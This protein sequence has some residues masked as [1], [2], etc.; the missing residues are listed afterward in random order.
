MAKTYKEYEKDLFENTS[1]GEGSFFKW[2]AE[3]PT[4]PKDVNITGE[5]EGGIP[6]TESGRIIEEGRRFQK[7]WIADPL[8]APFQIAGNILTPKWKGKNLFG[9]ENYWL[10]SDADRHARSVEMNHM[11][12]NRAKRDSVHDKIN[13][14][15]KAG[16]DKYQETGDIEHLRNVDQMRKEILH[17]SNLTEQDLKGLGQS[18]YANYDAS[19]TWTSTPDPYPVIGTGMN[20]TGSVG[21]SLKGWK[22]G[23]KHWTKRFLAG[24]GKG[25]RTAKG[26]WMGRAA[27]AVL[28]GMAGVGAMDYGYEAML[29]IMSSAG[30]AKNWL[31]KSDSQQLKLISKAIPENLTFG[32]EGINRPDQATRLKNA[33][34]EMALDGAIG[35]V[36]FGARPAY[37]GLRKTIGSGVFRMFKQPAG[38]GVT[39]GEEIMNAEQRLYKELG[40]NPT[41]GEK[42]VLRVPILGMI[43]KVNEA[44]TSLTKGKLFNWLGPSEYKQSRFFPSL[45]EVGGTN[46]RRHE[47]GSPMLAGLMKVFGRAPFLGTLAYKNIARKMD[48]LMDIGENLLGRLAPYQGAKEM[49]VDFTKLS[50]KSLKGFSD[51]AKAKEKALLSAADEYGAVVNDKTLVDTAKKIVQF[52]DDTLQ[53]GLRDTDRFGGEAVAS[54]IASSVP[55]PLINFL[56]NQ[57]LNTSTGART[58]KQMYGLRGQI[59]AMR[60]NL[61]KGMYGNVSDDLSNVIRAWETDIASLSKDGAPEV[62]RLWK[63]YEDFVSNGMLIWGTDV[64][65]AVGKVKRYGFN[66]QVANDPVRASHSLWKTLVDVAQKDP[67]LAELNIKALKNIVGAKAYN[68][69]LGVHIANSFNDSIISKEGAE[70]FDAD[71]FRRALGLGKAG[72]TTGSFFKS[73]LPGE[74]ITATK[75]ID[76]AGIEKT[77]I[78]D[79]YNRSLADAGIEVG[80]GL[81]KTVADRLPTH[82]MFEDFTTLMESAAKNG[83]PEISTFMQR[84]AVMSGVRNTI[85]SSLPSGA[86][87]VQTKTVGAAAAGVLFPGW[88]KSAALAWGA[89]YMAGVLTNPVSMRV[90]MNTIDDT[91]PEA[92]RLLNFTKLVRMFPEEWQDFDKELAELEGEQ[93]YFDN[94]Q[95]IQS[96]PNEI[97]QATEGVKDMIMKGGANVLETLDAIEPTAPEMIDKYLNP[98]KKGGFA[99]EAVDLIPGDELSSNR[100]TGSSLTGSNVM[101]T[102]AA[103]ALYTGDTDAALAY[104][105][106][107]PQYAAEGGL[108]QLNPVMDNQGKYNTPQSQMNDNPFTK[109]AKGGGILSV[110]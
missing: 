62:F 32:A 96:A 47:I 50:R 44:M 72:K 81:T 26:G 80:E 61:E 100:L 58:I 30:R 76:E 65:Q 71:M 99:D 57:V 42:A 2:R 94:T 64:G 43:P 86:L 28:G 92:L 56:K 46:I 41:T 48:D 77:F 23:Q 27:G 5:T 69:G 60:G 35:T 8:M 7:K 11:R 107:Q 89:R 68:K 24:A 22:Y 19:G 9:K 90:Y 14:L 17:A 34:K 18:A 63:D 59:D 12:L 106:G 87:G 74:T 31:S 67:A 109:S 51:V 95:K 75:Y 10:M 39:G 52:Y 33:A 97:K 1:P 16:V 15:T 49:G 55:A 98:P 110:L 93:R 6:Q 21:G 73:A 108:M 102:Q 104:N 4:G 66:L 25:A 82:K 29:D 85:R 45:D 38:K 3:E 83:I 91:L 20:I 40:V 13:I 84:R 37:Y 105:A 103:Q 88:V 78:D 54:K 101:N 36:F 53:T 70:F 79:L